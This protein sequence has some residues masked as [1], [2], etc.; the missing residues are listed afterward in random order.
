M[1]ENGKSTANGTTKRRRFLQMVGIST[2]PASVGCLG[3]SDDEAEEVTGEDKMGGHFR[4]ATGS[5]PDSLDPLTYTGGGGY[6]VSK[7]GYSNLTQLDENLEAVPDIAT[8]WSANEDATVWTFQL[9]DDATFNHTDEPV[10]AEVVADTFN[11]IYTDEAASPGTGEIGPIDF[12]EATGENEVEIHMERPYADLPTTV[13]SQWARILPEDIIEGDT[14]QM[15]NDMFGSGAFILDD[16]SVGDSAHLSRNEDYHVVDDEDVQL[17]YLDEISMEVIPEETAQ[18]TSL[19]NEEVDMVHAVPPE[20]ADRVEGMPDAELLEIPGGRH[21]PIMMDGREPPFDDQRVIRAMKYATD[22]EEILAGAG[23]GR[24]ALAQDTPVSPAH[25]FYTELDS[26]WGDTAQIEEAQELLDEAGYG[27]GIELDF[28][29]ISPSEEA[30][31]IRQTS[32]LFQEQMAE[33]GIEYEIEEVTW[34]TFLGEYETVHP[35]YIAPFDFRPASIQILEL[36]YGEGAVFNGNY[37]HDAYPDSFEEFRE[38]LDAVAAEPDPEAREELFENIQENVR[39][40]SPMITPFFSPRIS[41]K[42][43]YVEG[44]RPHPI[45]SRLRA[46]EWHLTSDAPTK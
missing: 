13:S 9:R 33:I 36:L 42:N 11:L 15:A 27:D 10:T 19:E 1:A 21:F 40:N 4:F 39:E 30:Q 18:L 22:R 44:V 23:Q 14:D 5:A 20:Q 26:R 28:P 31:E 37:W 32:V 17:P 8:E 38:D 3:G 24:G 45:R 7:W 41:A 6:I 46:K 25:R 34:D 16:Y 29:F 43:D 35:F 2:L 12:A